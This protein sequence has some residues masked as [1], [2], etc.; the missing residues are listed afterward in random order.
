M[1]KRT[2]SVQKRRSQFSD[3]AIRAWK[4]GDRDAL[5]FALGLQ[6]W[7]PHVLDVREDYTPPDDGK[8]WSQ[9]YAEVLE[10]RREL[11]QVAGEPPAT[12]EE[13]T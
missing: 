11:I 7:A 12:E 6:P 2:S 8:A 3:E 4:A 5:Y 9:D 1:G 10:L 13:K